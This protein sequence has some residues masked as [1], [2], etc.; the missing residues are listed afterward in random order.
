MA[1][2]DV[3]KQ[4]FVDRPAAP[5]GPQAL[6]IGKAPRALGIVENSLL[7]APAKADTGGTHPQAGSQNTNFGKTQRC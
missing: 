3:A 1:G 5:A 4:H 7:P 2:G 6:E